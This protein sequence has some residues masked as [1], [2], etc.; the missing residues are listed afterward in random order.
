MERKELGRV[1]RHRPLGSSQIFAVYC[2]KQNRHRGKNGRHPNSKKKRNRS[3]S[4]FP[5]MQGGGGP[6]T[7]LQVKTA[8]SNIT[9][10]KIREGSRQQCI[11][12]ANGRKGGT[13]G[14][15]RG[16]EREGQRDGE[17]SRTVAGGWGKEKEGGVARNLL[18]RFRVNVFCM[19]NSQTR[20]APGGRSPPSPILEKARPQK[21][22]REGEKASPA[23][24][25]GG[26]L[27]EP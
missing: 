14:A 11:K 16:G 21:K 23:S 27:K 4:S 19:R 10:E 6:R 3:R 15:S 25:T 5:A 8:R 13:G 7:I 17:R 12:G 1:A 24:S 22:K 20:G 2:S 26:V 9:A 18:K